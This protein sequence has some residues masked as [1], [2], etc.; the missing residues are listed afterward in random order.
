MTK[1]LLLFLLPSF[2][3][4]QTPRLVIPVGHTS[5]V[6]AAAFSPDGKTVLTGSAD[7]TA[8]LWD[9]SGRELQ[10]FHGHTSSI[11]S[12]AF[13]PDGKT[14]LTGSAD[15]TAKLWDLSGREL[16][17]FVG[18]TGDIWSVAF[19][20]DGKQVMTGSW[21]KTAKLWD[22]SGRALQTFSG[23]ASTIWSVAFSPDGETVLTGSGDGTVQLWDLSGKRLRTYSGHTKVVKSVAFSPDGKQVLTGSYD[24]TA[25]LWS[26][27]GKTLHTFS[28]HLSYVNSVTFSPNGKYVLTGSSDNTARLW[29]LTGS[30]LWAFKGHTNGV[31]S[32]A[33]SPDGKQVLTGN[34]DN[35]ARLWAFSGGQLQ[36]FT[37][38]SSA[39]F[40]VAFS[41]DGKQI[42]T[43]GDD[44]IARLWDI[45]GRTM[46]HF[47]GHTSYINSV[48]FSPDGKTVLTGSSDNTA[49]LW[50]H[51][52]TQLQTFSGHTA[53]VGSVAFS[54]DGKLV[55]TGS[56]DSTAMLWD[57]SGEQLETFS[58]H[59][60]RVRS[61][62]FSPDGKQILTGSEDKTAK[63][64]DLSGKEVQ[65]FIGHTFAIS[66]VAFSPACSDGSADN[67]QILTGSWD[68]TAKLWDKAGRAL[69]TFSGHTSGINSVAFSQPC[70]DNQG[71]QI[72]TNSRD[73]TTKLWDVL[74][75]GLQSLSDHGS[76]V[77]SGA[78]SPNGKLILTG[79]D[80]NTAKLWDTHTGKLLAT[81][82]AIDSTDWVVTTPSGLFDASDGARNL[83]HYVVDLNQEQIVVG[84]EQIQERYW[85][86][87]LLGAILGN[88]PYPVRDVGVFEDLRLFPAFD[89]STRIE[90]G[91]L[92]V[93]L[94]E[95]NGGLG[96]L[97]LIINGITRAED[98]NPERKKDFSIDLSRFSRFF[99]VD[100]VNTLDLELYESGNQLK[101][102][103]FT[104]PYQVSVQK[105]GEGE[106]EKNLANDCQMP[107]NLYLIVVGTSLY[108]QGMD[109]LPSANED[110]LEMARVLQAAG[111]Q[112]YDERVHIKLL[113]TRGGDVP[114]KANIAAAFDALKTTSAC[115]V[116]V[117]FFAGHGANWGKDGDKSNFYYLT[118][119]ITFGKLNDDGIRKA[120]AISD[121]ELKDWMREIPAENKL[122]ILDACNSGQAAIN[123]GGIIARNMDPDKILAFNLMSGNTGS[124]V[125]SGSSESGASFES[126]V[127]GHGLLTYSLL[128]GINGTALDGSKVD[129]L[130]LLLKSYR[131]VGELAKSLDKEQTPIIAKPR[132][133]AS[134]YVGRNDGSIRIDLPETKP[135][136]IQ[137][138]L[139]DSQ[140]YVDNLD[141]T[142]ALNTLFR[143]KGIKGKQAPWFYSDISRHSQGFS[144]RGIYTVQ[145]DK[146]VKV[147]GRLIKGDTP[148]G[149]PFT[150]V[151]EPNA[152]SL[153][154]L[155]YQ[156]VWESIKLE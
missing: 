111:K 20:P 52:G 110:A 12:V 90:S 36:T 76:S 100:T 126:E 30:Y 79:S 13:S 120:Y 70:T 10:T 145:S 106:S 135:M 77:N 46:Q 19:S 102:E 3:Q 142:T 156:A 62:A 88:T 4:A 73:K 133:N 119:D 132:G 23:S 49:I 68:K 8:K 137:S 130:P 59:F 44:N 14:V 28:G 138:F 136:V 139:F 32:V 67:W 56:N 55:L 104:L 124:Y 6:Y 37:G 65:T 127:F 85:Q 25:R 64:W 42:L 72:L 98:L 108:P 2:L 69:Q 40:S 18:H 94:R 60:G 121:Q 22:L 53:E 118:Q 41:P 78:F 129:V 154:Q 87:G 151:G 95:R 86:P 74:G 21:D 140:S 112:L 75:Q 47:S 115:D 155:I 153:A 50:S 39:N 116:L 43:G 26:L 7:H 97:S 89:D 125:I 45:S 122:L 101:S 61:V 17:T 5:V 152:R 71:I 29:R 33:F 150:I 57:L 82:I 113:A 51:S 141:I 99:R 15:S 103:P 92:Y 11:R 80:D 91:R 123:M 16:R 131:R 148:Q 24:K 107:R 83:M 128:E 27:S 149:A 58:G 143:S 81:L 34:V 9:L 38:H 1:T 93:K 134:F 147:Q 84:L 63:L 31:L 105:R 35:T 66:A 114:S 144:V 109:S 96:K 54:P 48:A 117:V 146:K